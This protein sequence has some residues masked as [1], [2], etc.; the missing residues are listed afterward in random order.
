M[1]ELNV[2]A[3]VIIPMSSNSAAKHVV[4]QTA[5]NRGGLHYIATEYLSLPVLRKLDTCIRDEL[6]YGK[7]E[8]G[9][10]KVGPVECHDLFWHILV[11]LPLNRV[12]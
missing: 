1:D 8:R 4:Q 7:H 12:H 6:L 11:E 10:A 9:F 2:L 3:V 5:R